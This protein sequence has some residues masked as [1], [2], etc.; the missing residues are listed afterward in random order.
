VKKIPHSSPINSFI[1]FIYSLQN[2]QSFEVLPLLLTP[3]KISGKIQAKRKKILF[4]AHEQT[5]QC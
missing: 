4:T 3:P 5:T 2:H 1:A